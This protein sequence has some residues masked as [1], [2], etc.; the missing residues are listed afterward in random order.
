MAEL[1]L[2]KLEVE[3]LSPV[4]LT[5]RPAECVALT[6]PSGSGK[7]RLLRAVCDMEP[8]SGAI[9]L[10]ETYC[11][12]T[13]AP[14]WRKRVGFLPTESR[15]W[16]EAVGEHFH[17]V[18]EKGLD[19]MGLD[20]EVMQW[21]V[22][23]LSSGERQRLAVLRLLA[24]VPDALLLDEPTANLDPSNRDRVEFFLTDYI[25]RNGAACLWVS[26]DS[27][28]MGRIARRCYEIRDGR[29]FQV[30]EGGP[31]N[32]RAAAADTGSR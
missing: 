29:L 28:Q 24:N 30:R 32:G 8:H 27:E 15:W 12:Q 13:P 22:S 19:R 20:P 23:R 17:G 14:L 31:S 6:G 9:R 2:E 16:K 11:E 26:H 5:V 21:P 25:H 18:P 3:G 7:T 1:V 10:G 4:D